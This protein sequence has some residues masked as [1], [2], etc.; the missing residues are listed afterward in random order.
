MKAAASL[1]GVGVTRLTKAI[2]DGKLPART[3]TS[4][5]GHRQYL[6]SRGV[7]NRA[8]GVRSDTIGSTELRAIWGISKAQLHL[9]DEAGVLEKITAGDGYGVADGKFSK[10]R[11]ED[12]TSA[13]RGSLWEATGDMISFGEINLRKTTD[14]M[15]VV[16]VFRAIFDGILSPVD[17]PESARLNDFAFCKK[18]VEHTM[19]TSSKPL[20]MTIEEVASILGQK[21]QCVGWWAKTGLLKSTQVPHAGK[22]RQVLSREALSAFQAEFIPVSMLA[23]RTGRSSRK[24]LE[25]LKT[26]GIKTHGS[27][28]EGNTTRGHLVRAADLVVA[29][30]EEEKTVDAADRN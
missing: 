1:I 4:Q 9:L 26:R 23:K 10:S 24:I 6:V 25:T 8:A 7:A 13:L 29:L 22:E 17:A 14:R 11:A 15:A 3:S 12:A 18:A 30:F 21:P 28:P 19:A 20:G 16:Q 2:D 5:S 27:F